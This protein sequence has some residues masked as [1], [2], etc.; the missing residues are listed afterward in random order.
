M[1]ILFKSLQRFNLDN[2]CIGLCVETSEIYFNVVLSGTWA[3]RLDDDTPQTVQIVIVIGRIVGGAE[4]AA[5][6]G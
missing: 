1:K 2:V 5:V 6:A 3:G 4:G